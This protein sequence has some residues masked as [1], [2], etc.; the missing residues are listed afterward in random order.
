MKQIEVK[1]SDASYMIDIGR[2][3]E[4]SL[5]YEIKAV[6]DNRKIL[7]VT[8]KFF[9]DKKAK[10]M[11]EVLEGA[12]FECLIY[13]MAGGKSSK[14]FAELLAIYGLLEAEGFS[15]DSTLVALGGGVIGDLGGFAASTWYRGMNLV[16]VPTT[17]MAMVDSS[18]GGKVAINFRETINAVGSYYHPLLNL[19][20]LEIIDTL[21]QRDYISGLA[22][23][24][25][26]GLIADAQFLDWLEDNAI[27]ILARNEDALV[28]CIHKAIQIKVSHVDG[29]L[30][31]DGKRLLLNFG[32]TLGH[33]IEMATQ[34]K[35]GETYRHGEG[36]SLGMVAA[37]V[38][39]KNFFKKDSECLERV[40]SI[41]KKFNLPVSI[42][43][44]SVGFSRDSLIDLC[45]NLSFKDK[46]R[47]NNSLR[48]ILLEHIGTATVHSNVPSE[49]VKHALTY[50]ITD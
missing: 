48:F 29:D 35:T 4:S 20:D 2:N 43:A 17:L 38:I 1:I 39:A 14:S 15:R 16:H 41:L 13:E 7:L 6:T 19:M 45:F 49:L 9:A 47:K 18:I 46:K 24:I 11:V 30:K 25:K 31:E 22:E 10:K 33:A 50:L 8:D 3:L 28:H 44:S 34:T 21:S 42:S 5:I 12:G 32:H 27:R 23:V 37:M 26:C 40:I 36:V